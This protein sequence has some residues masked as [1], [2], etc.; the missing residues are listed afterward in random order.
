MSAAR[1]AARRSSSN[2]QVASRAASPWAMSQVSFGSVRGSVTPWFSRASRSRSMPTPNPALGVLAELRLLRREE[3]HQRIAIP[4]FALAVAEAV[5]LE[6]QVLHAAAAI[7]V[8][9]EQDALDVLLR[10]GDAE[11]LD[12]ELVV[13]AQ[14][15]H[16]RP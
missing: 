8:H 13:L 15:A 5:D 7:K 12:A 1:P 4:L 3:R 2:C 11:R 14:P 6:L 16:G 10:L 9:L